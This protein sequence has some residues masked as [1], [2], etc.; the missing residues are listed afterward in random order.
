METFKIQK[1]NFNFLIFYKNI[2]FIFK[3]FNKWLFLN[4]NQGWN[5]TFP[6]KK[7]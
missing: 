7:K 5:F 1:I 4:R 6:N 2:H 3:Y